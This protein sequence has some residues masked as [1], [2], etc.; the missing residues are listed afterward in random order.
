MVTS[1]GAFRAR[2]A[3]MA[4]VSSIL[5]L[6]VA[7]SPPDISFSSPLYTRTAP[8]PPGPGFLRHDPSV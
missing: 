8:H 3:S 6:V 5:L 1:Q 2:S 7:A 4:A